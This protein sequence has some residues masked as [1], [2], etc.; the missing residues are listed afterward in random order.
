MIASSL[1][2][3][4]RQ[5]DAPTLPSCDAIKLA[6]VTSL[7]DLHVTDLYSRA[8]RKKAQEGVP[9]IRKS[10]VSRCRSI[11]LKVSVVLVR[12]NGVAS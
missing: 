8:E 12:Y 1:N 5:R 9:R 4:G 7:P 10:A 11:P 3:A 6:Y 2:L